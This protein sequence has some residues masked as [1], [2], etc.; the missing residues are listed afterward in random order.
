MFCSDSLNCLIWPFYCL[1]PVQD[2]ACASAHKANRGGEIVLN[3]Q[4]FS[5]RSK[6]STKAVSAA[7]SV[8]L[9][10]EKTCEESTSFDLT[11]YEVASAISAVDR[12]LVE[13]VKAT[14]A[15]AAGADDCNLDCRSGCGLLFTFTLE[16]AC[17]ERCC[18]LGV[19]RLG[20]Y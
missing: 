5:I 8:L 6:K 16:V 9:L 13:Q 12:L 11:P 15:G 18:L 3:T 17:L 2:C 14:D 7:G 20:K 1:L 4:S 19:H 10:Q